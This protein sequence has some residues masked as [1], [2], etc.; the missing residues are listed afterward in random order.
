MK[1]KTFASQRNPMIPLHDR[2]PQ[3]KYNDRMIVELNRTWISESIYRAV[4]QT[5]RSRWWAEHLAGGIAYYLQTDIKEPEVD[6]KFLEEAIRSV[7]Q[8][9]N[10]TENSVHF[11]LLPPQSVISLYNLAETSSST[12]SE[13][14]FFQ[15]L[16]D[17]I[18]QKINI[19]FCHLYLCDLRRAV[20]FISGSHSWRKK[21][22]ELQQ[23]ILHFISEQLLKCC[24]QPPLRIVVT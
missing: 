23:E 3:V 18:T 1:S 19:G 10:A 21:C 13:L 17:V 24:A 9:I 12:P 22:A 11:D 7:L 15:A 6:K 14:H 2:L 16:R 20:R 4:S 5:G 8:R